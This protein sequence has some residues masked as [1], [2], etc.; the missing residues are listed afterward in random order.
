MSMKKFL[1][2][3]L[4]LVMIFQILPMAALAEWIG[5]DSNTLEGADVEEAFEISFSLDDDASKK[6]ERGLR[7]L[8]SFLGGNNDKPQDTPES[9]TR[10]RGEKLGKLP[11]KSN[12]KHHYGWYDKEGKRYVTSE[13]VID[14]NMT[15]TPVGANEDAYTKSVGDV[16]VKV[17][18]N[19]VPESAEFTAVPLSAKDA[20]ALVGDA[21]AARAVDMTFPDKNIGEEVQPSQPVEVTMSVAGMD[22][23]NLVL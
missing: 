21:G 18:E 4:S 7:K 9:R 5:V 23:D 2:M 1:A 17:P 15:L 8:F 16:T 3:L 13:T 20:A 11:E 14:R 12:K 10:R 19:T 6:E 22:T